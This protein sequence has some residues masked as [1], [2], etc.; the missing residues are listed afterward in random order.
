M[1]VT[2]STETETLGT[3][4][5]LKETGHQKNDGDSNP[6]KLSSVKT[7]MHTYIYIYIYYLSPKNEYTVIISS[8]SWCSNP[9]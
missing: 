5:S 3:K 1:T 7:C 8:P 4:T 9:V 6:F 2:F